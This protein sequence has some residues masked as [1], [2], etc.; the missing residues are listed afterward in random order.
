MECIE[1]AKGLGLDVQA[2]Q[3]FAQHGV[4]WVALQGGAPQAAGAFGVARDPQHFGQVGGNFDIV[5][6]AVG[7][8]EQGQGFG[9]IALAVGEPAQ[10]VGDKGV[11]GGVLQCFFNQAACLGQ[12]FAAIGQ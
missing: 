5:A 10:A 2:L 7:V 1:C 3:S 9:Q 11:V 6:Q 8:F 4:V 12:L